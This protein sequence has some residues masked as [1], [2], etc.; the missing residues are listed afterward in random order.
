MFVPRS[1]CCSLLAADRQ[2]NPD[3]SPWEITAALRKQ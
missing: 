2:L 3:D 1:R